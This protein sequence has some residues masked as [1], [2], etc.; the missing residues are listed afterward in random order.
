LKRVQTLRIDPPS[1]WNAK[2][3]PALD[4]VVMTSL[5]RNPDQRWQ[6]AS[7]MRNAFAY[8]AQK[9]PTS[10]Q[11]AAWLEETMGPARPSDASAVSIEIALI[12]EAMTVNARKPGFAEHLVTGARRAQRT[13]LWALVAVLG[14]IVVALAAYL[15][16]R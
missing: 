9:L 3:P 6:K 14:L 15:V 10:Q 8:V 11:V 7:A 16:A 4:D 13:R 2:I 12:E 1:T 5:A